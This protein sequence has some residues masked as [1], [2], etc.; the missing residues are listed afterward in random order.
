[1]SYVFKLYTP[2][3][4]TLRSQISL[5]PFLHSQ[6]QLLC[7]DL[8]VQRSLDVMNRSLN[9]LTWSINVGKAYFLIQ[10]SNVAFYCLILNINFQSRLPRHLRK[11]QNIKEKPR[12]KKAEK[13]REK[14]DIQRKRINFI[15]LIIIVI[16]KLVYEDIFSKQKQYIIKETK[17]SRK[18]SK[19]IKCDC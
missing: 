13:K 4:R 19:T 1:M 18:S 17:R 11:L 9:L 12:K 10:S 16:F 2:Q 3:H 5:F 6:E 14:T 7:K 15:Y 8:C